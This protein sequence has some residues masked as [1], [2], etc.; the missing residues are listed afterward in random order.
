M[1]V[2]DMDVV[3]KSTFQEGDSGRSQD[4]Q[5]KLEGTYKTGAHVGSQRRCDRIG[6]KINMMRCFL[7]NS[8]NLIE[9]SIF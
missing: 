4:G 9:S 2:N 7:K 1:E 8:S 6:K 3:M 5:P